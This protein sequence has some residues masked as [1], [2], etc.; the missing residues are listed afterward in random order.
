LLFAA[1]TFYFGTH[2]MSK[3]FTCSGNWNAN[4]DTNFIRRQHVNFQAK[5]NGHPKV[6]VSLF[7][8]QVLLEPVS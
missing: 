7:A 6:P 3:V 5:K 1:P 2:G 8:E 4:V